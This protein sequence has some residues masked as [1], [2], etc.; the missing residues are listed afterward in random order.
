LEFGQGLNPQTWTQIGTDSTN[1]VNE[2]ILGSWDTSDLSG[3]YILR[4]L[5][6]R[7]DRRVEQA[8]VA[9][10]VGEK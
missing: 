9:V 6:V 10:M 2:D 5:V 3:L 1:P 4:L 8:V 7:T